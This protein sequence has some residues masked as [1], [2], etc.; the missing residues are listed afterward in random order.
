MTYSS[1]LNLNKG[2]YF[3]ALSAD[4]AVNPLTIDGVTSYALGSLA[5]PRVYT[6]T[7]A[8]AWNAGTVAFPAVCGDKTAQNGA[9]Y[10]VPVFILGS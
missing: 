4:V 5:N 10:Y 3:L 1:P 9:G 2:T 6:G 7:N 8:A